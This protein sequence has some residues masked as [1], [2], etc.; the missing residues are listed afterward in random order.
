MKLSYTYNEGLSKGETLLKEI[1]DESHAFE[2]LDGNSVGEIL[3]VF[4]IG[5]SGATDRAGK[6][7]KIKQKL[8][9]V[10]VDEK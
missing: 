10:I 5:D 2:G 4:K 6:I 7:A 8:L 9:D 3:Q 1:L